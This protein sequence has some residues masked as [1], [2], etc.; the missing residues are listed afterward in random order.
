MPFSSGSSAAASHIRKT[1]VPVGTRENVVVVH[2]ED[3][4]HFYCQLVRSQEA[5]DSL[6]SELENYGKSHTGMSVQKVE[7]GAPVVARYTADDEW[8]RAVI[9]GS[10]VYVILS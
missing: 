2:T 3:P 8:Y 1:T 5:L 4:G 10:V 6:M 9:T 7:I